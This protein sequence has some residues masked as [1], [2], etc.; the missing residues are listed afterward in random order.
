MATQKLVVTATRSLLPQKF[1][2]W[3]EGMPAGNH[4]YLLHQV[5]VAHSTVL[6]PRTT[7]PVEQREG[8]FFAVV[9][10]GL[11]FFSHYSCLVRVRIDDIV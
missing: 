3:V 7:T 9:H 1:S 4:S 5:I 2:L 10:R 8:V 6:R 11:K